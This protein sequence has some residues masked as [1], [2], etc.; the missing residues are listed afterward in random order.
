MPPRTAEACLEG[1]SKRTLKREP[2]VLGLHSEDSST[3]ASAPPP[4]WLSRKEVRMYEAEPNQ[5]NK[6]WPAAIFAKVGDDGGLLGDWLDTAD[7]IAANERNLVRWWFHPS[8]NRSFMHDGRDHH[9]PD[10]VLF[11]NRE[12]LSFIGETASGIAEHGQAFAAWARL[13][14]HD[15]EQ[16]IRFEE[17]FLG[18][19]PSA[20]EFVSEVLDELGPVVTEGTGGDHQVRILT[21]TS[22][23]AEE[24][25][26]RGD[27]YTIENPEGGVWVFR[28][29]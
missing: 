15:P 3:G 10:L 18:G 9:K 21:G 26:R 6:D 25:Q 29:S 17:A 16:L 12:S 27:I 8:S 28:R 13:V 22:E 5:N 1:G 4:K 20:E 23:L 24:L 14:G 19:W 2:L 7:S 11:G